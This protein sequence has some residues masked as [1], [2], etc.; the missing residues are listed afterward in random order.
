MKNNGNILILTPDEVSL[1]ELRDGLV[2][3][4]NVFTANDTRSAA[5]IL[6][7]FDMDVAMVAER[8]PNMS[9]LQFCESVH[10]TFPQL[11]TVLMTSGQDM[12]AVK[13]AVKA[14]RLFAY[15]KSGFDADEAQ[16]VLSLAV[17]QVRL[18]SDNTSLSLELKRSV[19]EQTRIMELFKRYVPEQVVSQ[20]L[21]RNTDDVMVGETRV[22]SI[23]FADIRNFTR[24]AARVSPTDVVSFLNDFW[25]IMTEPVRNNLGSVNKLIGDGVLAVFGAPNS[26]LENQQNAVQCALDMMEALKKVNIMYRD[27]LGEEIKIGIGINTGEVVVG[28]IGTADYLEYTV[29][30][31]AV[32]V[33]SRIETM[34]K[35][36]P[37]SILISESTMVEVDE[38]YETTEVESLEMNGKKE[39]VRVFEVTGR[40]AANIR[41]IGRTGTHRGY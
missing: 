12:H 11:L 41:P 9:G 37:N 36:K 10:A 20:T 35:R 13:A 33:A 29:I 19:D 30:G 2:P 40:R 21:Y 34:T 22:V 38:A 4:F 17:Q 1:G 16:V 24:F 23:L 32:N 27:V 7:E 15:L 28:N 25:T 5:R 14:K 31:D 26:Y 3:Y 18:L 39:P 8:L 6:K